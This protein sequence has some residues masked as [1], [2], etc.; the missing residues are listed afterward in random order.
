MK[1]SVVM[2]LVFMSVRLTGFPVHARSKL[3]ICDL[4]AF[5]EE[6]KSFTQ[7]NADPYLR[8]TAVQFVLC[9][10]ASLLIGIA[11]SLALNWK[12]GLGGGL[13]LFTVLYIL[14]GELAQTHT[15]FFWHATKTAAETR[16]SSRAV[17]CFQ[18]QFLLFV[19]SACQ[20]CFCTSII[21]FAGGGRI[22]FT[23]LSL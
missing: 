21:Q 2:S 9:F 23:S 17:R 6:M 15:N 11:L 19:I 7:H 18:L 12:W 3:W 4:C 13:G 20:D 14:L 16:A 5:A 8:F 10:V 1:T 22:S